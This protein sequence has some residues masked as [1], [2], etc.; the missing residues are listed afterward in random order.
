MKK[1]LFLVA[2]GLLFP[3]AGFAQDKPT[4]D[5]KNLVIKEW[6]TDPKGGHK[7]LDHVTTF[8]PEGQKI[9]WLMKQRPDSATHCAPCTQHST[10]IV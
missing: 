10:S 7:A 1:Y 5:K 2:I 6:N 9:E 3:L 8:N 4:M